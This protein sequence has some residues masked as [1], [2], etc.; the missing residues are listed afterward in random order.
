MYSVGTTCD[1]TQGWG[2]LEPSGPLW[3]GM[4]AGCGRLK[5]E[6]STDV[7]SAEMKAGL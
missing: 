5:L 4:S 1:E 2:V 3:L 6:I 7:I